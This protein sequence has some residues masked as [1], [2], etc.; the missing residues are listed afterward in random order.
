MTHDEQDEENAKLALT[1][2]CPTCDAWTDEE[3]TVKKYYQFTYHL[4]RVNLAKKAQR[5]KHARSAVGR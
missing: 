3:C 4:A 2:P 1:V 5:I